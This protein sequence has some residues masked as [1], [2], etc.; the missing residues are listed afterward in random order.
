[1]GVEQTPA[2][3]SQSIIS[4][5]DLVLLG[6]GPRTAEGVQELSKKIQP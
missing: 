3:K 1:M 5:D 6:F 4:V 2:G